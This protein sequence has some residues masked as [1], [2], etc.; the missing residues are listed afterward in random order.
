MGNTIKNQPKQPGGLHSYMVRWNELAEKATALG[1]IKGV[2]VHT[3][4]FESYPKAEKRV[5]WLEEQIKAREAQAAVQTTTK[6]APV[7]IAPV[8][9]PDITAVVTEAAIERAKAK[10][11]RK[12]KKTDKAQAEP[13]PSAKKA[14]NFRRRSRKVVAA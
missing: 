7:E 1:G 13:G 10:A 3:S 11:S 5:R 2:K 6:P 4:E 9:E 14:A 12:G 8:T